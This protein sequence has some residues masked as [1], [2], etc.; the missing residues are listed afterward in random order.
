MYW[1]IRGLLYVDVA[2]SL[3][4]VR[5]GL[6]SPTVVDRAAASVTPKVESWLRQ[7]CT[8]STFPLLFYCSLGKMNRVHDHESVVVIMHPESFGG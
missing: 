3:G 5:S 2:L 1:Y 4:R 7:C 6:E 8:K